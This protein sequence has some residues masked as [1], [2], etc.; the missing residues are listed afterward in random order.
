MS[1]YE[2]AKAA[3]KIQRE[4]ERVTMEKEDRKLRDEFAELLRE[5]TGVSDFTVRGYGAGMS[6]EIEGVVFAPDMR[7]YTIFGSIPG[8][9][10]VIERAEGTRKTSGLICTAGDLGRELERQVND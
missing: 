4:S 9:L 7:F 3:W 1:M 6:A 10:I 2:R 5:V 8:V